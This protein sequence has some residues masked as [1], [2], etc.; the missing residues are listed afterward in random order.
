MLG[1][2]TRHTHAQQHTDK[3]E[4]ASRTLSQPHGASGGGHR[5]ARLPNVAALPLPRATPR[6]SPHGCV[7]RPAPRPHTQPRSAPCTHR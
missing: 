6:P 1:I 3:R 7:A 2:F 4:V 5:A